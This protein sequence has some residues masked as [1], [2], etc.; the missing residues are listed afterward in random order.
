MILFLFEDLF[1]TAKS[2]MGL[3]IKQGVLS[4]IVNDR[5]LQKFDF[6]KKENFLPLKLTAIGIAVEGN[7]IELRR[8]DVLSLNDVKRLLKDCHLI[9]IGIF[10]KTFERSLNGFS[11]LEAAGFFSPILILSKP[12]ADL[13]Q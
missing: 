12:T 7:I 5:Q 11:F 2:I 9:I 3:I 6:T 4:C 10:E 1:S 13:L 8:K